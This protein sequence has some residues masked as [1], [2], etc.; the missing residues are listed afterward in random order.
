MVQM[1]TMT[2]LAVLL[3]SV[4]SFLTIDDDEGIDGYFITMIIL[5]LG[6][7]VM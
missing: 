1:M 7:F 2:A 6:L 3:S 5:V 4:E